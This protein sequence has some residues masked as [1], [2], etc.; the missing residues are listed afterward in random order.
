MGDRKENE[1]TYST[2]IIPK[3]L[4]E[5]L[6]PIYS[7]FSIKTGRKNLWECVR[8]CGVPVWN[9][10][11]VQQRIYGIIKYWDKDKNQDWINSLQEHAMHTRQ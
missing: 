1:K 3:V 11:F 2:P 8:V 10:A 7:D 9:F 4:L 6:G 5:R